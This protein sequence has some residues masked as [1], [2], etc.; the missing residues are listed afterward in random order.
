M[1]PQQDILYRTCSDEFVTNRTKGRVSERWA[2]H[3]ATDP[4][5]RVTI[6]NADEHMC[7]A[8]ESNRATHAEY[9]FS[10]EK[11]AGSLKVLFGTYVTER[12]I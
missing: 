8:Q 9:E 6:R 4:Q 12:L 7:K 2:G 3:M 11:Y 10:R 5:M 1:K